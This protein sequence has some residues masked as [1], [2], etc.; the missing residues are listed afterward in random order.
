MELLLVKDYT[1]VSCFQVTFS[2]CCTQGY[3]LI[4][5]MQTIVIGRRITK[6]CM[7]NHR[8]PKVIIITVI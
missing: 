2:P 1:K 4:M 6:D 3:M 7:Y 8:Q 5:D